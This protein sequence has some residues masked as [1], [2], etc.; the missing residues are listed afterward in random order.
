MTILLMKKLG[1][2]TVA[3]LLILISMAIYFGSISSY[4]RADDTFRGVTASISMTSFDRSY[5]LALFTFN[6][7]LSNYG[8]LDIHL[9]NLSG[10]VTIGDEPVY[11]SEL[12]S[13]TITSGSTCTLVL[14]E[15]TL[16]VPVVG[17]AFRDFGNGMIKVGVTFS[18]T[19]ST[20]GLTRNI[21]F[22]GSALTPFWN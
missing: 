17:E 11:I 12:G 21:T 10:A 15:K 16:V 1:I 3:A 22:T 14:T 9:S 5:G 20:A 2:L 6:S 19:A 8:P 13:V 4:K 7:T 18:G